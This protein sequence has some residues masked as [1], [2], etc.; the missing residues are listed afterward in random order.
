MNLDY[1]GLV[2]RSFKLAVQHKYF[3]LFGFF[4][5]A[6]DWAGSISNSG[7]NLSG[8]ADDRDVREFFE[9]MNID[10][11]DWAFIAVLILFA[12]LIWLI[13]LVMKFL[14]EGALAHGV[15][16][17]DL[18]QTTSFSDCWKAGVEKFWRLL[19]ILLIFGALTFIA[20]ISAIILAIP[21]VIATIAVSKA[22]LILLIPFFL[23]VLFAIIFLSEG[24]STY[25]IRYAVCEDRIFSDA[26]TKA[27]HLFKDNLGKTFVLG[28]VTGLVQFF[29]GIGFLIV[30]AIMAV[31]LFLLSDVVPIPLLLVIGALLAF[32][33]LVPF[34]CL[35]G[36]YSSAYWTFAFN[37]LT[38]K[39]EG[40]D[41]TD[42]IA[43]PPAVS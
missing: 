17:V 26:I 8:R 13:L 43:D 32:V 1:F 21:L 2:G 3:W 40:S 14:S 23:I 25:A 29:A 37:I 42:Q 36:V 11:I 38:G 5:A 6:A 41:D 24:I 9:S 15:C 16:R 39:V 19:G 10:R 30:V 22:F 4:V 7:Q 12:L 35:I 18:G 31:P 28:L 20:V 33:V 34:S 27:W